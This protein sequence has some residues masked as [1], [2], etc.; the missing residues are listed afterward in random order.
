MFLPMTLKRNEGL[1]RAAV[2][3]HQEGNIPANTYVV[4]L[5]SF[6]SNVKVIQQ[7]AK[8]YDVSL[9]YMTKQLGRSGFIGQIIEQQGIEKAVA[10]D[11]DEAIQLKERSCQIGNIGHIVQPSRSQWK[12]VLTKLNPEVVTIFSYERAKQLSEAAVNVGKVQ[13]VILR[14]VYSHDAVFPGQYGGFL[15]EELEGQLQKLQRLKGISVVGITSFPIFELNPDNN[16]YQFTPNMTSLLQGKKLLEASGIQVKQVNAPSA[17]SCRTIPMLSEIGVTHGEPGH[18]LT[19]TTPL[20]AY[21]ED[22]PEVPCMVYVSE[23]SHMDDTHAYT[24]AG[25][26]YSRSGMEGALFGAHADAAVAQRAKVD[27]VSPTNIDYYGALDRCKEMNVGDSVIYAFR[28]QIFVTRA[29][30]AFVR[31]IKQKPEVVYFQKRGM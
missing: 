23:I 26:F 17:T 16:D 19:G 31:N 13:D 8:R 27:L 29:H 21:Q 12:F 1:I 4:D 30:V 22:M 15:I 6:E 7:T 10:V 24:I 14:I 18:A 25:G 9:Y 11:I 28:T 20:H 3:L 5:D 2:K